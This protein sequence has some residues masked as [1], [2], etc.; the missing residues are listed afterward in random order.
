MLKKK[1]FDNQNF[2]FPNIKTKEDYVVWLKLSQNWIKMY[3]IKKN[4]SYWRKLDNSLSSSSIQKIFDGYS[5]YSEYLNYSM[6]RSL[7]RLTILS[8][9]SL[10]KK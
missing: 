5:V 10:L 6:I 4:Y 2:Y 3:G 7:L 8:I 1:L 9:N